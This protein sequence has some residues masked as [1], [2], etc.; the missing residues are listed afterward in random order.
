MTFGPSTLHYIRTPPGRERRRDGK[1]RPKTHPIPEPNGLRQD[2][3][4]LHRTPAL[5]GQL[6]LAARPAEPNLHLLFRCDFTLDAL[7]ATAVLHLAAESAAMAILNHRELGR[8]AP[9]SYPHQHYHESFDCRDALVVGRNRLAIVARYIGI[10]SSASIPKDPGLLAELELDGAR[11]IGSDAT[12]RCLVLD[13]WQERQRRSEWLNLD[14]VE[15]VDRR[16]LPAGFP[17]PDDMGGALVPE[18]LPWPGVRFT[19]VEPRPFAKA[20]P[21]GEARLTPVG[22][23]SVAD[24]SAVHPIPA[25]A[26]SEEMIETQPFVWDGRSPFTVPAQAPGRAFAL[27]LALDGYHSGRPELEVEGPAGAAVD[28]AWEE[29]LVAGRFDVRQ[30][31]VYTADRHILAAGRNRIVPEDWITG[32]VLQ[33]TFRGLAAP[34]RVHRLRFLREEYPLRQRLAFAS[35]DPRL[36]RIV[37]ISLQ[38]VRRCMHDNI[39]DCPWRERRQWIGDVQRIALINHYAFADRNLVRAVLRQHV[40][41]QEPNGRM[42]CC[43]P[44]REEFPTQSMEWL[45][46]V[47]EYGGCTGDGTLLAEVL[48]NIGLLHHWFLGRRGPNARRWPRGS[49]TIS[50]IPAP[51]C[52]ATVRP[53]AEPPAPS[54]NSATPWPSTPVCCRWRKADAC[55]TALPPRRNGARTTSS[56]SRLSAATTS[57]RPG[58]GSD[59]MTPLSPTSSPSG[60]RWPTPAPKPRGRI[61]PARPAIATAGPAFRWFRWPA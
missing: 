44:I 57:T 40:G 38:A 50:P 3:E 34:L 11:S 37:A 56:P 42:W 1:P 31:R 51:A 5:E 8:T 21:C 49:R 29:K 14:Q 7:P 23:G 46:A 24:L 13:A 39:M 20:L 22:A 2:H 17:Y 19:G 43:V 59:V 33:L 52:S 6:D 55:G 60:G 26:M 53:E 10:P 30:T 32:R 27:Q 25:I 41:M 18:A 61:S 9:N 15:I 58:P 28:I 45:R 54:A 16:L 48:P 12:W 47:L 35:S 4:H 36:E